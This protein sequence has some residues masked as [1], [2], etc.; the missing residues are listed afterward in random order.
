[1]RQ[2]KH[3]MPRSALIGAVI[4]ALVMS[5]ATVVHARQ[6]PALAAPQAAMAEAPQPTAQ[7]VADCGVEWAG[8]RKEFLP[9]ER[10]T[11]CRGDVLTFQDDGN[12]VVYNRDG[13]PIWAAGSNHTP[14]GKAVFQGETDGNLVVYKADG[15]PN[16]CSCVASPRGT[17]RFRE[18]G[19]TVFNGANPVWTTDYSMTDV[20]APADFDGDGVTDSGVYRPSTGQWIWTGSM[21]GLTTKTEQF[22]VAGDIPVPADYTGDGIAE[23]AVFRPSNSTWYVD[24][25]E[26]VA[27]GQP[28]DIPAP[29]DFNPPGTS[30][31]GRKANRAIFRPSTGTWWVHGLSQ[32]GVVQFGQ[33]GDIPVPGYYDFDNSMNRAVWRPSTGQWLV[34][35]LTSPAQSSIGWG[36]PGDIPMPSMVYRD[37]ATAGYQ[38]HPTIYRPSDGTFWIHG[39]SNIQYGRPGDKPVGGKFDQVGLATPAVYRPATG[40]WHFHGFSSGV[41][42]GGNGDVPVPA[43]Y[44]HFDK[45]VELTVFRPSSGT[46]HKMLPMGVNNPAIPLGQQGDIPVPQRWS[47]QLQA[48]IPAVF[49]PSNGTWYGIGSGAVQWGQSGDVPVPADYNGDGVAEIAVYR[50]SDSMWHI[51]Q[52]GHFQ[53]GTTGD[54]PVPGDYDGDKRADRAVFRPSDGTWRI[55][56]SIDPPIQLGQAGDVPM[57]ADYNGDGFLDAAVYRPSNRTWY[58]DGMQPVQFG[59][60][61]DVP[62]PADYDGDGKAN[63]GVFRPSQGA[64]FMHNLRPD[65]SCGMEWPT[66]TVFRPGDSFAGCDGGRFTFETDGNLA[67]YDESGTRY[68]SSETAGTGVRAEFGTD[69]DLAVFDA[70]NQRVWSAGTAALNGRLSFDDR[71][72][73]VV[74]RQNPQ[75]PEFLQP[76]YM[77]LRKRK[78][79][80]IEELNKNL[81]QLQTMCQDP[82]AHGLTREKCEAM[83][84]AFEGLKQK[85]NDYDPLKPCLRNPLDVAKAILEFVDKSSELAGG[86]LMVGISKELL[87]FLKG[88]GAAVVALYALLGVFAGCVEK[89]LLEEQ[90][91][92]NPT[93]AG[94]RIGFERQR[95]FINPEPTVIIIDLP[96]RQTG[97]GDLVNITFCEEVVYDNQ[98]GPETCTPTGPSGAGTQGG[99]TAQHNF[100]FWLYVAFYFVGL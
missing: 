12:F 38:W 28:G 5:S 97:S 6:S 9:G 8:I 88:V 45:K 63:L 56:G 44:Y 73:L 79:K 18:G 76:D 93:P 21:T 27:W 37:T 74:Y 13:A 55:E 34:H 22:G 65:R 86:V 39:R 58:V 4:L 20:P 29:G 68:F 66:G 19:A 72:G 81:D 70:G 3:L 1:M 92:K 96:P 33:A 71:A 49:R 98:P 14:A 89:K 61:G 75:K 17:L 62:L 52:V 25:A 67:L 31:I 64:W 2:Q 23:R 59:E 53:W 50:P 94:P 69:G 57:Q 46:W 11:N 60:A 24:G 54:I 30:N 41:A 84:V 95:N 47:P 82:A 35:G 90:L 99:P 36:L 77:I 42:F 26:T 85:L 80:M 78:E 10:H 51:N 48:T 91:W 100:A 16:W 87:K 40:T 15:A 83:T 32:G 43:N 7:S